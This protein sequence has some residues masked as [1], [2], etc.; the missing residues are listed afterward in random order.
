MNVSLLNRLAIMELHQLRNIV[1]FIYKC[2]TRK[3][4]D[5]SLPENFYIHND[6]LY[7]PDQYIFGTNKLIWQPS[8][9]FKNGYGKHIH[10][11]DFLSTK[12]RIKNT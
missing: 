2:E 1:P 5:V 11:S 9:Y 8:L 12:Y 4:V 3:N 6:Y 7:T 10:F